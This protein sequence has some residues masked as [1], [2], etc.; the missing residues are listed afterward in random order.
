MVKNHNKND[1]PKS[2]SAGSSN[3][4]L[5]IQIYGRGPIELD[6]FRLHKS[7]IGYLLINSK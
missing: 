5:V 4:E 2:K 1:L 3:N 6:P 7:R